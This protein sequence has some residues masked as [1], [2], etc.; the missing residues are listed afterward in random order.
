MAL[1][2]FVALLI[3]V[4]LL[5]S[6]ISYLR[7]PR[8]RPPDYFGDAGTPSVG[9]GYPVS[10]AEARGG[11]TA[12]THDDGGSGGAASDGTDSGGGGSGDGGG[13]GGGSD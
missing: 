8:P 5:L 13:D 2:K 4:I 7:D 3:V 6:F 1:I 9:G 11:G 10:D 12:S